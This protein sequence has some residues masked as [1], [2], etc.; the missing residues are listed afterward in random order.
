MF[1]NSKIP[2]NTFFYF[3]LLTAFIIYSF[4][5]LSTRFIANNIVF[6]TLVDDAMISMRYAKH[7]SMGAGLVW[8][9]GDA[10]I[11]GFSNLGLVLIMSLAHLFSLYESQISFF[12]MLFNASVL[13]TSLFVIKKIINL[14][15]NGDLF[16]EIMGISLMVFYYPLIFWSLRGLEVGIISL[17]LNISLLKILEL[18]IAWRRTSVI[19]LT[20]CSFLLI[21]TRLDTLI[22][23][24][25]IYLYLFIVFYPTKPKSVLLSYSI[26]FL[27]SSL[28]LIFLMV[29]FGDLFPNTFYLK[30]SGQNLGERIL[31][32]S[33]YFFQF[34]LPAIAPF[35]V[36]V[37]LSF[38]DLLKNKHKKFLLLLLVLFF[39]M[40]LYTIYIGGDYAEVE[41]GGTNRFITSSIGCLFVLFAIS[42]SL[43]TK[44]ILHK[45]LPHNGNL[46][47]GKILFIIFFVSV[48]YS[49]GLSWIDH[50][51]GKIPLFN[52]DVNRVRMGLFIKG[53]TDR[54]AIIAVFAAGQIPYYTNL[55]TV[56]LLGKND[57]IIANKSVEHLIKP[58]HN[59]RD[60]N[61][62]ILT[63]YPDVIVDEF[64][65]LDNW[66]RF[67]KL[68][69]VRFGSYWIRGSS[70]HTNF[71][72]YFY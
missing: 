59:K 24:I 3:L 50:F 42:I 11:Q 64:Y 6:F 13:I 60:Y 48:F 28:Y 31:F 43:L 54:D 56:D 37:F 70:K 8:N 69:Y 29:Y 67:N 55:K 45:I 23:I 51:N 65:E 39:S 40:V 30:I 44:K 26:F 12:I 57:R 36:I 25:I 21:L 49:S 34:S 22:F 61:Y 4:F 71:P 27:L 38:T 19:I 20:I 17:L 52:D 35:V 5:I 58:G 7:L 46:L 32:G 10:P 53:H 63:Y 47:L 16:T 72:D 33:N 41:V 9:L 68:D 15:T 1:K 18:E 14:L 66:M 62:S 2:S